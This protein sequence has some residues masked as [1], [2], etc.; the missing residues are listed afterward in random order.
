W[1]AGRN[2]GWCFRTR[3]SSCTSPPPSPLIKHTRRFLLCAIRKATAR[4]AAAAASH[5]LPTGV[6]ERRTKMSHDAPR[7]EAAQS[8]IRKINMPTTTDYPALLDL[9]TQTHYPLRSGQSF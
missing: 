9:Q 8:D 4:A 3:V 2:E 6:A 1:R 7:R 5:P